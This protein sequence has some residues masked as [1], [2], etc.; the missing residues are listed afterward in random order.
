ML[1]GPVHSTPSCSAPGR[2]I[3]GLAA[4]DWAG[5][6][7]QPAPCRQD[8]S[9][10]GDSP[11]QFVLLGLVADVLDERLHTL[12]CWPVP[13]GPGSWTEGFV[14]GTSARRQHG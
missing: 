3:W 9:Q 14:P 8:H 5:D 12:S 2:A 10:T 6:Q 11:S 13:V 4:R 7:P 1:K